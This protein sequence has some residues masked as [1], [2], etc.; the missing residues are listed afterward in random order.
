MGLT[1]LRKNGADL[2][3]LTTDKQR[4]FALE[5][6]LDTTK[7]MEAAI[8]AG[9][10]KNSASITAQKLLKNPI[11]KAFIGKMEREVVED[12]EVKGEIS[13]RE[14]MVKLFHA[15]T[16]RADDL[17]DKDGKILLPQELPDRVQCQVDGM[18]Q[19]ILKRTTYEDG[20]TEEILEVEYKM[21]PRATAREQAIK[22]AGL[23]APE[24]H[25]VRPVSTIPWTELVQNGEVDV[26][27]VEQRLLEEEK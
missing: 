10:S 21:T 6:L 5:M 18:K 27:L 1:K 23:F 3:R 12:L 25:D 16:W 4:R 13:Q 14:I 17:V 11:I 24:K 20:T 26:D 19:K 8:R 22:I 15:L 7:P 9:Y 2:N